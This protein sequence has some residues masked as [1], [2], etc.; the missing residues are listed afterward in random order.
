LIEFGTR[1][2]FR[3]PLAR[4]A[5]YRAASE[6]DGAG[7]AAMSSCQEGICGTGETAVI[8]GEPERYDPVLSDAERASGEVMMICSSWSRSRRL[9]LDIVSNRPLTPV[10]RSAPGASMVVGPLVA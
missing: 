7:I 10:P 6:P 5:A 1:V 9:V 3:H 2:R 4:T 8:E